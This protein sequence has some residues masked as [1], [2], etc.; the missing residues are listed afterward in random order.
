MNFFQLILNGLKFYSR[1]YLLV[2]LGAA[3]GALVLS[4]ALVVG[5]SLRGSLYERAVRQT[6]G[7][8]SALVATRFFEE[9]L[10]QRIPETIPLL[11]L[12]GPVR[13][14]NKTQPQSTILGVDDRFGLKQ[15]TP[16]SGAVLSQSLAQS[17]G[18]QIGD[19]ISVSL[20]KASAAPKGSSLAKRDTA[21]VTKTF[22]VSVQEILPVDHP[23]NE[24]TLNPGPSSPFNLLLPLRLVQQESD[25]AG[26]VNVLVS[27]TQS[28]Q[29]LQPN[30]QKQ[31]SLA[32]WGLTI[33]LGEE[34]KTYLSVASQ[35]VYLEPTTVQA[36]EQSAKEL[37]LASARTFVHLA[38]AL[39]KNPKGPE[40]PYSV[41]GAIERIVLP[42]EVTQMPNPVREAL[43]PYGEI[44]L[45]EE[46]IILIDW[47]A[48]VLRVQ[49][50]E[51]IEMYYF[52][53]DIETDATETSTKLKVKAIIPLAGAAKDRDLVPTFPGITDKDSIGRWE[54]PFELTRTIN[55]RDDDYWKDYRT[56]PKGYVSA[57]TAQRIW[58]SRF[59][60]VTSV[61]VC[62]LEGGDP[63]SK[64]AELRAKILSHL[65]PSEGGFVFESIPDRIKQAGGGSTDF[66]GLFLGFSFFIIV[67]GILLVGL[68]FRLNLDKR[69]KEV[70]LLR[71]VGYRSGT[72]RGVLLG[73]G[74]LISILGSGLGT[75]LSPLYAKGMLQLF[76]SFWP[77]TQSAQMLQVHTR[78]TTLVLGFIIGVVVAI[79]AIL[80]AI[81][82]QTKR[83]AVELL[84]GGSE[85][86]LNQAAPSWL[87]IVS[88][89]CVII[90]VILGG[91]GPS[92][93]AGE[94][95][96]GAFFGSG[97]LLLM[98]GTLLLLWS[99]RR[100][101]RKVAKSLALLSFRNVQRNPTRA[102]LTAGLLS[103]A[104]FLLIAVETF[105][106]SPSND[107]LSEKGGSGGFVIYAETD[108]PI[109]FDLTSEKALYEINSALRGKYEREEG[110]APAKSRD[111]ADAQT[112]TLEGM[113]VVP[114]RVRTGDDASCLNLYQASRPR[115]VGIPT[116]A[117]A[118][119][120]SFAQTLART[121]EQKKNPW[122]L[123]EEFEG[124]IFPIF[125]EANT[126]QWALKKSLGE[127]ITLT[128]ESGQELVFRIVGLLKDSIFQ[129]ELVTSEKVFLRSFPKSEGYSAFLINPKAPNSI[130]SVSS[131]LAD[132]LRAYGFVTKD[133]KN[134]L[135]NFLEV[136]NA[137]LSTF[138]LLGGLGMILGILGLAIVLLRN[139]YERRGELALMSATGY[140]R[141]QL[142]QLVLMETGILLG[143]GLL[144]GIIPALAAVA[145]HFAS[146][147]S[148]PLT[149]LIFLIATT[150]IVGFIA[151]T[152][153]VVRNVQ[154]QVI[155]ALKKE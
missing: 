76:S 68:L 71:S 78:P 60:D 102:I 25:Q 93:P 128:N 10:A 43:N 66:G 2:L 16:T 14:G 137:Y 132:G 104:I 48:K 87:W 143:L 97:S 45:A 33:K 7:L 79:L 17:L 110:M 115:V 54:T 70:G 34:R 111:L 63:S 130:D 82:S 142:I 90:A 8:Q 81:R 9:S 18:I 69:A 52:R 145:P 40:V 149:R 58:G 44:P 29:S 37:G 107:F 86:M 20:Q 138:Q 100:V 57:S 15:Y 89:V 116:S 91:I 101:P 19:T 152:L 50:G 129:R 27:Q 41:I 105:R 32:D 62:S 64:I 42:E 119:R 30:L 85:P 113:Q 136:Q 99:L 114:L 144:L 12:Q 26:R 6:G 13:N 150:G 46:E 5:D 59:G 108:T 140:R 38:T 35:R 49:T 51:M 118:G 139:I 148:L 24:F 124:E 151:T 4:G 23:M 146:G 67:A 3:V 147:N 121:E 65:K 92:L 94:P 123:L 125:V 133:P 96:A 153:A 72:I 84:K 55:R 122:L 120:F 83:E 61:R 77:D 21:S 36:I 88:V 155:Y 56:T 39:L 127:T 95:Q 75:L 141:W 103:S 112:E 73:E 106:R 135:A 131:T 134:I 47:A 53:P 22:R 126:A 11:L 1:G 28:A 98:A 109:L 154:P 31:L 74:L 80:W 117:V